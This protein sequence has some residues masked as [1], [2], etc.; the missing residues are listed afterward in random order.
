MACDCIAR[1]LLE[2]GCA[3]QAVPVIVLG[4]HIAYKV[5]RSVEH[6]VSMRLLQV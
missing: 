6:T 4:E 2:I 5:L 3:I 1:E